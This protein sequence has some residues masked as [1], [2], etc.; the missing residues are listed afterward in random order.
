MARAT[1]TSRGYGASHQRMRAKY[2]TL[3][4]SGRAV[5]V[6]C[7]EPIAPDAPWDL[8]HSD[9]RRTYNGPAHR[10]CNRAAGARNSTAARMAKA[11]MTV[12]DW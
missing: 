10:A 9:D 5:C 3:V 1:T 7:D 12:R 8:D 2:Q 4:A 6:R 11:A